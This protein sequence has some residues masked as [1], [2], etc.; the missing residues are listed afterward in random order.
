MTSVNFGISLE[1]LSQGASDLFLFC[2]KISEKWNL[3]GVAS[4]NESSDKRKN[5]Y[6]KNAKIFVFM[7]EDYK[8][9]DYNKPYLLSNI[10][11]YTK[12]DENMEKN[13]ILMGVDSVNEQSDKSKNK[14]NK[15]A[16]IFV[17]MGEDYKK[18]DY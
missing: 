4:L 15:N 18:F 8:K 7:D 9:F 6:N 14:Y 16:K 10:K 3:N 17:F 2:R 1:I 11:F 12:N 13:G 5:K